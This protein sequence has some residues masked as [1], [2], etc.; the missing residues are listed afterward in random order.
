MGGETRFAPIVMLLIVASLI[1]AFFSEIAA[2]ANQEAGVHWLYPRAQYRP[3]EVEYGGVRLQFSGH[4][5]TTGGSCQQVAQDVIS[6]QLPAGTDGTVDL[7]ATRS[8]A[9]AVNIKTDSRP[10]GW[11]ALKPADPASGW[12]TVTARYTFTIP[13]GS[14]GQRFELRFQ[15]WTIGVPNVLNLKFIIDATAP[16]PPHTYPAPPKVPTV[17]KVPLIQVEPTRLDFGKVGAGDVGERELTIKNVGEA[18]LWVS[19]VNIKGGAKSPFD[20]CGKIWSA[21]PLPPGTSVKLKV[22]FTPKTG[23]VFNDHVIIQSNDPAKPVVSAPVEG[24]A[25]KQKSTISCTAMGRPKPG[26]ITKIHE[27]V[28]ETEVIVTVEISPPCSAEY[29]LK[30]TDANG[31]IHGPYIYKTDTQGKDKRLL[32]VWGQL[33][34]WKLEGTWK[35][36]V[37]WKGDGE[38]EGGFKPMRV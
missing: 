1:P 36:E 12:G 2:A 21:Y 35:C 16:S 4:L 32:V 19:A 31:G 6:C 25:A 5:T 18:E 29:A 11:P 8:P 30:I 24:K 26:G 22:C 9:G 28:K 7:T 20:L 23:G 3:G 13:A 15:A 33:Q 37:S 38:Y 14:A 17:P 10:S 27:Y 34:D